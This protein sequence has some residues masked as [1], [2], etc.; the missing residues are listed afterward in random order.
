MVPL[1][2]LYILGDIGFGKFRSNQIVKVKDHFVIVSDTL[3][4]S[5]VVSTLIWKP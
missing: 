1:I 4:N 5:N 3:T 2:E